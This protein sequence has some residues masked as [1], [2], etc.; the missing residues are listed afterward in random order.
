MQREVS[1]MLRAE[2]IE[3]RLSNASPLEMAKT[4]NELEL[5]DQKEAMQVIEEV[6]Q[7]FDTGEHLTDNVIRP[8]ILCAVDGLLE[9][10]KFGRDA[11]KKGLTATRLVDECWNFTYNFEPT[12]DYRDGYIEYKNMRDETG[13]DADYTTSHEQDKDMK[14]YSE[15]YGGKEDYRNP[16]MTRVY[17]RM[18]VEDKNKMND[19]KKRQFDVTETT[20]DEYE[21]VDELVKGSDTQT[22]H[23]IAGK[24]SYDQFGK[25]PAL[26]EADLKSIINED[27]NFALTYGPLNNRKGDDLNENVKDLHKEG[28]P[29]NVREVMKRKSEEAQGFINTNV[30]TA[31]L[32]TLLGRGNIELLNVDRDKILKNAQ[33]MEALYEKKNGHKPTEKEK[34]IILQREFR[35][36]KKIL[37]DKLN[38]AINDEVEKQVAVFKEK[39]G[40]RE[41]NREER[42]EINKSITNNEKQKLRKQLQLQKAVN[43]YSNLGKAAYEQTKEYIKGSIIGNLIMIAL[44]PITYEL[45]D[46]YKNEVNSVEIKA[47]NSIEA[48][49]IRIKRACNYAFEQVKKIYD[50]I[51]EAIKDLVKS[52]LSSFAE[53]IINC[54]VGIFKVGLKILKEG[55]KILYRA[56]K[57]ITGKDGEG[58]T[59][60]QKNDAIIKLIGASVVALAGIAFEHVLRNLNAPQ[61]LIVPLSSFLTGV[62][63]VFFMYK[64]N[65]ADLFSCESEKRRNA[66]IKIFDARIAE[67]NE[68][69]K[70]MDTTA[71]TV[72]AKQRECYNKI[73]AA[74]KQAIDTEN[75]AELN[76]QIFL[77]AK[78]FKIELPYSNTESF[79]KHYDSV[80]ELALE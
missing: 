15:M 71:I 48:I 74:M 31:V 9:K 8:V 18:Q 56:H 23:I 20:K 43:T 66:V 37:N 5:Y 13:Y 33:E 34:R 32:N 4:L 70:A 27:D 10:T 36:E 19:Y 73:S 52:F 49:K 54:F 53:A 58:L 6:Y 67:I 75:Y 59:D 25:N 46:C 80:N 3:D 21:F 12:T 42:K 30:N 26:N 72:L 44:K 7:K 64:L 41:P 14:P 77:M 39:H 61:D 47:K 17:V 16:D 40:G 22:D 65:K 76:E 2:V 28:L 60:R 68:A 62:V 57:I 29:D 11:R 69:T 78:F 79:I 63:T 50:N 24:K 35:K 1:M 51:W 38:Q 45:K 55:V